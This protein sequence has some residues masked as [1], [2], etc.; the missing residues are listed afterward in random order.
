MK[1]IDNFL[2]KKDHTR[3]IEIFDNEVEWSYNNAIDYDEDYFFPE[4][5][6]FVTGIWTAGYPDFPFSEEII[7]MFSEKLGFRTLC[8]IKANLT[9]RKDKLMENSLHIDSKHGDLTAIYYLNTNNGYS[10]FEDGTKVNSVANRMV[11]FPMNILHSGTTSTDT[12]RTVINFN[13][14][15]TVAE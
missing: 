8:R 12:H 14:Y 9:P 15:G 10:Y 13:Y 2:S 7:E 11:I 5:Y 4:K 6:Q 3:L 1:I